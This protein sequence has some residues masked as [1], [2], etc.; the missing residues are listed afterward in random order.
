[1]KYSPQRSIS[2]NWIKKVIGS[3]VI[4]ATQSQI[5]Q[6][7]KGEEVIL[8]LESGQYYELNK[9]GTLVWNMIQE[10]R[11]VSAIKQ[12]IIEKYD[13]TEEVC[14]KDVLKFLQDLQ[15]NDLITYKEVIDG[16]Y[17]IT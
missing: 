13:L 14:E 7:L 11:T 2:Q 17:Y 4:E 1:M 8:H 9:V 15:E 12:T 5:S 6:N 16:Q 3:L 10:P